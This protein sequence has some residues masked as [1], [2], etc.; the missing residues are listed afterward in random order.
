[1]ANP[2]HIVLQDVRLSYAHLVEPWAWTPGTEAKY[3]TSILI[4]K[5]DER[6]ITLIQNA[7]KAALDAGLQRKFNGRKPAN[8]KLPL[9]DGDVER[10]DDPSYQGHY[11]LNAN[12]KQAPKLV[13]QQLN[14]ILDREEIYSGCYVNISLDFYAFSVNGNQGVAVSL[15]NVQKLRD[16]DSFGV[17]GAS[18]EDDFTVI[19]P[20]TPQAPQSTT[21]TTT[22]AD[23]WGDLF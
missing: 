3:S 20:T 12:S 18:V 2:T 4:N 7:V 9:R 21:F 22:G 15:R 14:P 8:P 23:N 17:Q 19:T 16:G 6:N 10:P 13:D 1:M 11:F 5:N